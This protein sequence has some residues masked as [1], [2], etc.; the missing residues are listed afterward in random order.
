M[1]S[2]R[3]PGQ[4]HDG[5]RAEA[6]FYIIS[7]AST[8]SASSNVDV[9]NEVRKDIWLVMQSLTRAPARCGNPS[10]SNALDQSHGCPTSKN[11]EKIVTGVTNG[12][13]LREELPG[14]VV[15]VQAQE[16]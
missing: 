9:T 8:L 3:S 4:E 12:Y 5:S 13:E 15:D 10:V 7:Q 14:R 1:R 11:L 6:S 2:R 16:A